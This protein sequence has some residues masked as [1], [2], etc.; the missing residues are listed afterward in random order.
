MGSGAGVVLISSTGECMEYAIRLHFR[1]TNNVIEYEAII[2]GL[3]I[4]SELGT[5]RLFIRG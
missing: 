3:K 2:H 4:A 1:A 5:R